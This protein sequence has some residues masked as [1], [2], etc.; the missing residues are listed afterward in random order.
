MNPTDWLN[1]IWESDMPSN[2]KYLAC[3]I[4]KFLHGDKRTCWP[5]KTRMVNETGLTKRTM[6]VEITDTQSHR[7]Q[8]AL[9]SYCIPIGAI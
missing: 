7:V 5:S 4:R 2:S 8:I 9:V 3:F 1:Q 6:V